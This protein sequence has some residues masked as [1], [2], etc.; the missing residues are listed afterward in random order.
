MSAGD[1]SNVLC[2]SKL[3]YELALTAS[4]LRIEFRKFKFQEQ[5]IEDRVQ[6][7]H[8]LPQQILHE[9]QQ[10]FLYENQ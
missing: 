7:L 9:V 10:D 2:A 3:H 1:D 6:R 8:R 4:L 5:E